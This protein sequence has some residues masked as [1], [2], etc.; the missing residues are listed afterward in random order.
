MSSV[1]LVD[2]PCNWRRLTHWK[3]SPKNYPDIGSLKGGH[4]CM[5]DNVNVMIAELEDIFDVRNWLS[6]NTRQKVIILG[7]FQWSEFNYRVDR[8][9]VGVNF[10]FDDEDEAFFFK[11]RWF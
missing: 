8:S 10:K 2:V 7:R 11:M 1:N 9:F 6:E 3:T 5:N 4:A